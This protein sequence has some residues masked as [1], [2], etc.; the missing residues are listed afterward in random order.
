MLGFHLC[1]LMGLLKWL[2][3]KV[4]PERCWLTHIFPL[5]HCFQKDDTKNNISWEETVPGIIHVVSLFLLERESTKLEFSNQDPKYCKDSW[6]PS[7]WNTRRWGPIC[8]V[9]LSWVWEDQLTV[10][11]LMSVWVVISLDLRECVSTERPAQELMWLCMDAEKL[12]LKSAMRCFCRPCHF[13]FSLCVS[14][15]YYSLL[16]PTCLENSICFSLLVIFS[17]SIC[18]AV[19]ATVAHM[20]LLPF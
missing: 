1:L 13:C 16:K 3:S 9:Y 6:S 4:T 10:C 8:P 2:T 14:L 17:V 12:G 19:Q 11:S 20:W 7:V 5:A 18:K 15:I